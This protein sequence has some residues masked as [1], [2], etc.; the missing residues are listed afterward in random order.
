MHKDELTQIAKEKQKLPPVRYRTY[1]IGIIFVIGVCFL[2]AYSE[3]VASRG[4]SI[5]AILLGATHMPP[6]AIA[7]LVVLLF[8]NA[9]LKRVS[10]RLKLSPAE[11]MV[12]YFMMVCAALM[13]SFGF[14]AEL[15]PSLMGVNYYATPE[16][17]WRSLFYKHIPSWLVPWDPSGPERQQ[18]SRSF[19]EGLRWGETIPWNHWI[20]PLAAWIALA[21]LLFFLMACTATLFRRQWVEGERLSFPLVQLPVEMASGESTSFTG[22]RLMWAGFA[23]PFLFHGLNGLHNMFP[24]IPSIKVM[25][26][27]NDYFVTRPLSDVYITPI[28]ISWSV[29]GFSYLLPMDVSF[30][31]WFF[32]LFFRFQDLMGSIMGYKFDNMP[33]YPTRFYVGYQ[34][35]GA[36]VVIAAAMLYFARPHLKMVAARV[37]GRCKDPIDANEFMSYRTAFWGGIISFALIVFWCSMAGMNPL[38]A[39]FMIF[40]F[41]FILVLVLTRCVSEVG[42]L[43]LQP[44]FRPMDLWAVVAPRAALGVQNL[45][46]MALLNGV[47]MRDPR[48]LM[49]VF[50]DSM[51]SADMVRA[52]KK[53]FAIGI[54]IAVITA[55][56]AACYF[57]LTTVYKYGG[58]RLN[59]WFFHVNSQLY[60][61]EAQGIL[62]GSKEFDPRAP[63]WFGVGII[64]TIFLY[65]MRTRL[66][67]WP[68]H[69]LG[70]AMGSAWPCIVY[71]SAF[72]VGWFLKAMI[73]R[74]GGPKT[75]R[76][77][78][79]FFLGLIFGEFTAGLLWTGIVALLGIQG[80][81]IPIT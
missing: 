72:F 60:F 7:G 55:A 68:F 75:Y 9:V 79:P 66:W 39:A 78:R 67:W 20:L 69:P 29:V 36:F 59:T 6:G 50:M 34:S 49:P 54:L 76:N 23:L 58:V 77:F 51:K 61:Q 35:A 31:F 16:G 28:V 47:F 37:T 70:Y 62:A 38:V 44:V 40:C 53:A 12:I 41:V 22:S 64:F 32:L 33:L 11:L 10:G 21:F 30:S 5:D 27:L 26:S 18:I 1:L 56:I 81:S 80:P 43:M 46:I 48:T 8:G 65:I 52:R 19:Y 45:T 13:S 4:G 63:M 24:T 25:W 57:Q 3:L 17:G 74:Y 14:A 15:L 73:L 71:W 42:L 2:L